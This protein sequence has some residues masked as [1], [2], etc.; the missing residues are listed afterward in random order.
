MSSK[1]SES[2]SLVVSI[3]VYALVI[4]LSYPVR[5]EWTIRLLY[6]LKVVAAMSMRIF[7]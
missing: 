6:T 1:H 4:Q 5:S 7:W 3:V 2:P